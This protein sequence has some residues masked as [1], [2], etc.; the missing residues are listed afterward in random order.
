MF[1]DQNNDLN[2]TRA[3]IA[4]QSREQ[5]MQRERLKREM[6]QIREYSRKIIEE[7]RAILDRINQQER[8]ISGSGP[9]TT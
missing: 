4:E 2:A 3:R 8:G 1:H 7:S 9:S 5:K 6:K